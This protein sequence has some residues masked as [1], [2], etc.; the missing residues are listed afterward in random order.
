MT[1]RSSRPHRAELSRRAVLRGAGVALAL[2][3]LESLGFRRFVAPAQA[4]SPPQRLL[5]YYVPNGMHMPAWTPKETGSEWTLSPILQPLAPFKSELLVLSGLSNLPGRP[6]GAGDHAGGTSAFLTCAKAN[7]SDSDIRLGVSIDQLA[8]AKL[9]VGTRFPSLQL[10]LDGGSS[11]GVCDSG[12]SCAYTTNISWSGPRTPLPKMFDPRVV[13]DV[14]FRGED[15]G[16]TPEQLERRRR[17]RKSVLDHVLADATRLQTRLGS[18][19]RRKLDEY[20]SAVRQVEARIEG[21]TPACGA[22]KRP[23]DMLRFDETAKAMAELMVLAFSCDLSRVI[24]Y[25]WGNGLS[26]RSYAFIGAPGAHHEISHHQDAPENLAK[27]QTINTY[28][29]QLLAYLVDG[30][31]K[32]QEGGQSLLDRTL[33]VLSSDVSDGNRHNHD[34]MPLLLVGRLGTAIQPGR[35]LRLSGQPLAN[36]YLSILHALSAPQPRFGDDSTGLLMGLDG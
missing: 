21:N 20:L 29:M 27:L 7:K 4:A 11:G 23:A 26:N 19:D 1:P 6:D 25:M 36:L 15:Q 34:N 18:T 31:K 30:L 13:F 9:G 24:S 12:Y 3:F 22:A 16:Q 2:P 32:T 28:E 35:H 33:I 14:L 17:Q 8:A 10:G 5:F